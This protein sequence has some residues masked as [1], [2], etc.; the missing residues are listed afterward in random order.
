MG[1]GKSAYQYLNNAIWKAINDKKPL[2][3]PSIQKD[4]GA[5]DFQLYGPETRRKI[6]ELLKGVNGQFFCD[7]IQSD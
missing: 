4:H 3:P 5:N 7:S 1:A 6:R 2:P